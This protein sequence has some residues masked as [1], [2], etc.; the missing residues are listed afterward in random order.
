MWSCLSGVVGSLEFKCAL[1]VAGFLPDEAALPAQET[2]VS[3]RPSRLGPPDSRLTK[4]HLLRALT[5][6][7]SGFR[8]TTASRQN[9]PACLQDR[10]SHNLASGPCRRNGESARTLRRLSP[11]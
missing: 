4:L 8:G 7:H 1:Q 10:Q 3:T 6:P 9:K 5:I 2:F 11:C